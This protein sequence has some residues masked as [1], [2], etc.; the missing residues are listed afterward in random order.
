MSQHILSATEVKP[1]GTN[2]HQSAPSYTN[3]HKKVPNL[4]QTVTIYPKLTKL[5]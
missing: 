1:N 4:H 5:H 3:L 2:L